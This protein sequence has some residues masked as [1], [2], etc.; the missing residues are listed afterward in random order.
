MTGGMA[1]FI[2]FGFAQFGA[3]GMVD[4][5][6]VPII[7]HI[8]GA[9]MV[10][11][12]GLL[13]TQAFLAGTGNLPLHR[14]LGWLS[15]IMVPLI[16]MIGSA[17]CITALRLEIFPPFFSGPY[18]LALVHVSILFFAALMATAIVRRK[19]TAWHKRLILGSTILLLE[20][21][22][23]RLLPMPLIMP[24]GEWLSL[25]I[26]LGVAW[27]IVRDDRRTLGSVHPATG[28][29]LATIVMSHVAYE[30]L[31]LVPAWQEFAAGITGT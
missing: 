26:Q 20:P 7:F 11:W 19:D 18:F 8:H 5:T 10:T 23:G 25:A 9:V 31:A 30:G 28:I 22:L 3:R 14:T 6:H 2:L 21:A 29:V 15:L 16:V 4:Y 24:W 13:V 17:T 1:L 27:Q 12:L